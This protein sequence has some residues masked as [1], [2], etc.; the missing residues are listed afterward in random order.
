M[1]A[2]L[3]IAT[4]AAHLVLLTV[5]LKHFR[6]LPVFCITITFSLLESVPLFVVLRWFPS[7][8]ASLYYGLDFI[9]TLLYCG[10]IIECA[11]KMPFVCHT[12]AI[13]ITPKFIAY[14]LVDSG[15]QLSPML[16]SILRPLN[17]LCLVLWTL[18]LLHYAENR[19]ELTYE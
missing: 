2:L 17:L 6:L 5:A 15:Q 1:S 19:K 16:W 11:R 3:W 12:M 10:S 8:Y 18:A 7:H 13:Y 14:W 9:T 4:I